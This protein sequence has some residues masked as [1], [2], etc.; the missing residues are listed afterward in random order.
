MLAWLR[1]P[2]VLPLV[3]I[4]LHA[5]DFALTLRGARDGFGKPQRRTWTSA[6]ATS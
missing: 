4:V 3:W 2:L 6:A 1:N 5:A